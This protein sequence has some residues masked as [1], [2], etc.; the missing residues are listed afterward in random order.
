MTARAPFPESQR[1]A[2]CPQRRR[3]DIFVAPASARFPSSVGAAYFAPDGA[4]L[5]CGV[6]F[7][8]RCRAY[9]APAPQR[10]FVAELDAEAAQMEAVRSLLPRFAAKIQRVLDRVWG[11]GVK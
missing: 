4:E 5:V 11:N 9:G 6:A 3:R 10:R 1:I 8:Q 2:Q 7:L